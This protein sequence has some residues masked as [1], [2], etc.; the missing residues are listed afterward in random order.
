MQASNS[1]VRTPEIEDEDDEDFY[2]KQRE[3]DAKEAEKARNWDDW[4]DDNPRGAGNKMM[5]MG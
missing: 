3:E 5:N 2:R 1:Q 4:K